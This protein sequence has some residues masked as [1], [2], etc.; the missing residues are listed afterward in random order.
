MMM[1]VHNVTPASLLEADCRVCV[2]DAVCD[3]NQRSM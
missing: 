2:Y 3:D 1:R